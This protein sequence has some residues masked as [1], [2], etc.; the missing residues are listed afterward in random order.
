MDS[1]DDEFIFQGIVAVKS[2]SAFPQIP[3]RP[4]FPPAS[5]AVQAGGNRGRP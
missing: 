1:P 4:N 3:L 5:S 2:F